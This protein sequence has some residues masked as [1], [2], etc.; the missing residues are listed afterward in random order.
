MGA[1]ELCRQHQLDLQ[2]CA[3]LR[4]VAGKLVNRESADQHPDGLC[5]GQTGQ[6]KIISFMRQKTDEATKKYGLNFSLIA[7]PAEGTSGTFIR[8]DK[9]VF[10]EIEGVT[11]RN[12]YTNSSH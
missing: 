8:K 11:D 6:N 9:K 2:G 5:S 1:A 3:A 12:Y 10:G 7:T 4:D